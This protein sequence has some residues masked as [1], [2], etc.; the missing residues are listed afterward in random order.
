MRMQSLVTRPTPD[1]YSPYYGKY[2]DRVPDGDLF[3]TLESQL[4]RT[5]EL[6]DTFGETGAALRYA[7][8]KWSVKEIVGHVT[9]AERI[10]SY[11]ALCAARGEPGALP[12]FDEN[13]YVAGA[14]FDAR[15]LNSLLGE[16]T[17][18]RRSTLALF[19]NLDDDALISRVVANGV[20]VT[21]RALAW[22]VAGHELHH[23]ALLRERYRPLL[24]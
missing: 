18:V 13:A 3:E 21:P 22:I 11:R 1:E 4:Q 12:G 20:P 5:V 7:P 23:A 8:G 10:F 24:A 6:L 14:H 17:A 16:L 9:D 19:R 15:T 2:I